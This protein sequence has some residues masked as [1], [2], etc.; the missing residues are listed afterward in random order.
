MRPPRVG[1]KKTREAA[2]KMKAPLRAA[3]AVSRRRRHQRHS[4]GSTAETVGAAAA[5]AGAPA[6][7]GSTEPPQPYHGPP[8]KAEPVPH[9]A[10]SLVTPSV[11]QVL[12]RVEGVVRDEAC[13]LRNELQ[14]VN[15]LQ[16]PHQQ[17]CNFGRQTTWLYVVMAMFTLF[18]AIC[19]PHAA[20][21]VVLAPNGL[22]DRKSVL[23][24]KAALFK[25]GA[26]TSGV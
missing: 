17:A 16:Q 6:E 21:A 2:A 14:R 9:G 19:A 25:I 22:S 3:A 24:P 8:V 5:I 15:K 7:P 20:R 1:Q 26:S 13:H 23:T 18:A 11:L 12:H 10:S 4:H